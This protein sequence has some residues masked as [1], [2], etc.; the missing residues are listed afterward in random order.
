MQDSREILVATKGSIAIAPV[1]T[2][3]PETEDEALHA[4][5]ADLGY[6]TPDGVAFAFSQAATDV[7]A[8]QE[9]EPIRQILTARGLNTTFNLLQFNRDSFALAFGG[10]SWSVD[11]G[12]YRYDPPDSD[13]AI[14]EY[15]CVVTFRD[16]EK[17]SRLVV[18]RGTAAEAVETS[19]KRTEASVLPITIKAIKPDDSD[20]RPWYYLSNDPA[21]AAGS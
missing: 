18:E 3:L 2:T 12:T 19:V 13:D 20:N 17:I 9:A 8:W 11:S 16:G 21:F 6:S 4:N 5:F 14:A 1:G 15:A 7:N 10:G